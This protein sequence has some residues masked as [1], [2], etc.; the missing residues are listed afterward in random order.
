MADIANGLALIADHL[1][2]SNKQL[3][4]NKNH[5]NNETKDHTR[6]G[7]DHHCCRKV[8]DEEV[9]NGGE[10]EEPAGGPSCNA[11]ESSIADA[12]AAAVV[13]L[14]SF[15]PPL[16]VEDNPPTVLCHVQ[17][18]RDG[19]GLL[20][21]VV[22]AGLLLC[23]AAFPPPPSTSLWLF[24]GAVAVAVAVASPLCCGAVVVIVVVSRGCLLL[25]SPSLARSQFHCPIAIAPRPSNDRMV[26]VPKSITKS[27]CGA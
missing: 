14:V 27:G 4:D 17:G 7:L 3:I 16:D 8:C 1:D 5:P 6:S 24:V 22:V 12:A 21:V 25:C 9:R 10:E 23:E 26:R 20:L 13:V 19:R 18:K 15:P 11:Y 2:G